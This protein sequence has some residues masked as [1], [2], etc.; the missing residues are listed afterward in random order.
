MV[1][2]LNTLKRLGARD[3]SSD[4]SLFQSKG[5]ASGINARSIDGFVMAHILFAH[6]PERKCTVLSK[7]KSLAFQGRIQRLKKGE[8]G[9]H[10]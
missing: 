2:L 5:K 7:A 6:T 3:S 4:S 9:I 10:I 8:G 1:A